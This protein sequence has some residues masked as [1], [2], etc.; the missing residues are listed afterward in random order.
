M[1]TKNPPTKSA[2]RTRNLQRSR[3]EIL[4]AAFIEVFKNG[5]QGVSVDE[6]IKKTDLTK[7]AF[8]HQFPTKMDLGYALVEEVITPM[9]LDR[10]I[11]PLENFKNPLEGILVQLQKNIGEVEIDQLKLG[12]PL[13]NLVQEMAPVDKG[14]KKKL[15]TALELWIDKIEWHLKR[16]KKAG[17]LS[18]DVSP[19][20]AANFIVMAHE[21]FYGMVKGL[22]DPSLVKSLF[23][24]IKIYF[25]SISN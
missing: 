2:T 16:G 14:F 13:N 7:G 6:I 18:D 3:Q 21:G 15:E 5:F 24:S 23:K 20:D 25:K 17:Y 22:S 11:L 4:D 10:W 1:T 12:C 8:Y 9:I 19:R